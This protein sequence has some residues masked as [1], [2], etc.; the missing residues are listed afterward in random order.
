MTAE[1]TLGAE[2]EL[3]LIDLATSKLLAWAPS[4]YPG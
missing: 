4:C 3:H 1:F 2:E